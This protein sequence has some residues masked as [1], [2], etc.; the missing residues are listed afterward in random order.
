MV[1][2]AVVDEAELLIFSSVLL[3]EQY[4]SMYPSFFLD[5]YLQQKLMLHLIH[6]IIISTQV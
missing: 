2:R 1:L 3:P 6:S 5:I 4:K